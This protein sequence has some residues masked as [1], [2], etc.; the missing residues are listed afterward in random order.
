V[1]LRAAATA[2]FH[3]RRGADFEYEALLGNRPPPLDYRN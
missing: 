1:E 3:A 2:E